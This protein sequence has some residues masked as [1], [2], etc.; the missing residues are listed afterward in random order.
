LKSV[1]NQRASD[2]ARDDGLHTIIFP[3]L[4]GGAVFADLRVHVDERCGAEAKGDANRVAG[5]P[6]ADGVVLRTA[7]AVG[8][9]SGAFTI[10]FIDQGSERH[11]MKMENNRWRAHC[12]LELERTGSGAA[13]DNINSEVRAKSFVNIGKGLTLGV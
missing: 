11:E 8:I 1:Q 13:V 6:G 5:I 4:E 10:P 3:D 9:R 7:E 2:I 12:K